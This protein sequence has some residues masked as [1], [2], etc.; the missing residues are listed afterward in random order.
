MG[1]T[2]VMMHNDFIILLNLNNRNKIVSPFCILTNT[3]DLK[4]DKQFNEIITRL[5]KVG[6]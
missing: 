3:E 4:K 6:T 1:K 5:Q 2:C